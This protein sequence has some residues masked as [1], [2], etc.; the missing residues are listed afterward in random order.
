MRR[1]SSKARKVA[2]ERSE[3]RLSLHALRGPYCEA[4]GTLRPH[5]DPS[6]WTDMHE[7]LSRGRGGDPTDPENIL[8]LCRW[9][10]HWVTVNPK[11][12]TE[13]GL[14]RG[15]TA[16]EHVAKFRISQIGT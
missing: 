6:P 2:S 10:H 14:L 5:E 3:I 7:V 13:L 1:Q 16:S 4:C 11:A 12:A 15:R 9:C 8:C